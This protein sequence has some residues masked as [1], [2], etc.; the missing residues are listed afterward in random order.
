MYIS[1]FKCPLN[2]ILEVNIVLYS[3]YL[4]T[5]VTTYLANNDVALKPMGQAKVMNT[6]ILPQ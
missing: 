4:I 1:C 2:Y 3:I 6:C 5:L